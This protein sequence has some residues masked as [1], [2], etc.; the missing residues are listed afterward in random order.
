MGGGVWNGTGR[1][2]PIV[3]CG[4]GPYIVGEAER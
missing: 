4:N 3:R 2:D 1:E